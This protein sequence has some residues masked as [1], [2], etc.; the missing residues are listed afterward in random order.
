MK[1]IPANLITEKNLLHSPNPWIILLE[2]TLTD[3]GPTI[4]RLA[5]NTEDV[6]FGGET[7]T[8]FPFRLDPIESNADGQ[9]P[10]VSL[11]VCNITRVLTP[12]LNSLDG[13]MGSTVKVVV[14]NSELLAEDYTELELE[15]TVLDCTSDAFWVTWSLGMINPLN[16]RFPLDRFLATHC[17]WAGNFKGAECGYAGAETA[18]DGTYESCIGYGNTARFGGFLGMQSDG[19]R[20]A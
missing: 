2:I 6:D 10:T 18:C 1:V 19:I 3:G 8:H 11:K 5:K 9:I 20:I 4:L 12:Y 7:Y 15:F 16:R 17:T 13:G 14:V